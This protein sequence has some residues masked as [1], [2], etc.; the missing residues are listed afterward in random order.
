MRPRTAAVNDIGP[1]QIQL[2]FGCLQVNGLA[3]RGHIDAVQL[4]LN[5]V[6][7]ILENDLIC[8]CGS[9]AVCLDDNCAF[10]IIF[11]AHAIRIIFS[12]SCSHHVNCANV[13]V[14]YTSNRILATGYSDAFD[15]DCAGTFI[16][17]AVYLRVDC[18]TVYVGDIDCAGAVI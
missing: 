3:L 6:E 8:C 5:K 14:I 12:C 2:R 11:Y 17:D 18:C 9:T 15:I 1:R 7:G 10:S 16:V 13:I 4:D